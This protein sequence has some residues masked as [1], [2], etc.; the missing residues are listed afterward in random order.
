VVALVGGGHADYRHRRGMGGSLSPET[1]ALTS[2]LPFA[3]MLSGAQ[4]EVSAAFAALADEV[5]AS[6]AVAGFLLAGIRALRL[7]L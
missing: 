4:G 2:L 7:V 5:K 1:D 3:A 6:N